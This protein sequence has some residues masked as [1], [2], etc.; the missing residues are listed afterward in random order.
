MLKLVVVKSVCTRVITRNPFMSKVKWSNLAANVGRLD[1]TFIWKYR[2]LVRVRTLWD[3]SLMQTC[4]FKKSELS[5]LFGY[6]HHM[7][8]WT[9]PATAYT[10]IEN[11]YAV[12]AIFLEKTL[13]HLLSWWLQYPAVLAKIQLWPGLS[14]TP[15]H[16]LQWHCSTSSSSTNIPYLIDV[17]PATG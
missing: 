8:Y 14:C 12:L 4:D 7:M 13:I 17:I 5:G 6:A 10:A 16:T 11:S 9:C 1:S 2:D 15:T 3:T